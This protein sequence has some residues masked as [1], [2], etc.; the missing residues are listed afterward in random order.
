MTR[1][2]FLLCSRKDL[3]EQTVSEPQGA[4]SFQLRIGAAQLLALG[5]SPDSL[6]E[7]ANWNYSTTSRLLGG[8]AKSAHWIWQAKSTLNPRRGVFEN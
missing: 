3:A 7:G 2:H 8:M 5:H 6:C 4:D 1:T